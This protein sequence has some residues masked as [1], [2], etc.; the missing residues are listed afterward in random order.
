MTDRDYRILA[1]VCVVFGLV[2]C[3]YDAVWYALPLA[4]I[5]T[6]CLIKIHFFPDDDDDDDQG[7]WRLK[8]A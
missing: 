1:W 4:L 2:F 5:S 7:P 6:G 3:L 8:A